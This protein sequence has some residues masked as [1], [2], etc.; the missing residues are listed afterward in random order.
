MFCLVLSHVAASG[1]TVEV[2]WY[3]YKNHPVRMFIG[4]F[5]DT[6]STICFL[7]S[8][9]GMIR[10][11]VRIINLDKRGSDSFGLV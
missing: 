10:H 8:S 6:L 2:A 1:R 11:M 5:N 3:F 7:V 9:G 4:L